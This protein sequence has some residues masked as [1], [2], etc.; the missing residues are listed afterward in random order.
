V[1]ISVTVLQLFKTVRVTPS[2]Q[3]CENRFI[4]NGIGYGKF[5]AVAMLL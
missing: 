2:A 4:S 3:N 1:T 5:S